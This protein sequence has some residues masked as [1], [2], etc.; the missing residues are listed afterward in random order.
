M[1]TLKKRK[2]ALF[3]LQVALYDSLNSSWKNYH[4]IITYSV[5]YCNLVWSGFDN[6]TIIRAKI[7]PWKLLPSRFTSFYEIDVIYLESKIVILLQEAYK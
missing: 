2:T 4:E 3:E 5:P 1:C 7:T 6:E